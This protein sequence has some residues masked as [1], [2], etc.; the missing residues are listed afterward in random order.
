MWTVGG[1][2]LDACLSN[3]VGAAGVPSNSRSLDG[4]AMLSRTAQ[5][6]L[7]AVA[8]LAH[9]FEEDPDRRLR[10]DEIVERTGAPR[11]YMSKVL[12]TLVREG[13]LDSSRGPTGGFRLSRPP[14]EL[15]LAEV[16]RPFDGSGGGVPG[17]LLR[18]APCDPDDPCVAHHRWKDLAGQVHRFFDRTTVGELL[19]GAKAA[20]SSGT[21]SPG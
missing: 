21:E 3:R 6:A 2:S 9:A 20:G 14:G 18:D 7:T 17:C 4:D 12:N 16:S 19:E 13:L 11:N 5:H 8:V 15:F 10:V 1:A